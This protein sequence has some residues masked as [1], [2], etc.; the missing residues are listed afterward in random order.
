MI[1]GLFAALIC[2]LLPATAFAWGGD[3]HQIVALIAEERL[4][5]EA[6]AMIHELLGDDVNISEPYTNPS[7]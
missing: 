3:G 5:P 4:A 7:R 6:K 1:R 2:A